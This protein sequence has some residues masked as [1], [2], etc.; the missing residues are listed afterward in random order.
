EKTLDTHRAFD[1]GASTI[2]HLLA[3][4]WNVPLFCGT[5]SR[6]VCDLNRS[7]HSASLWSDWTR[8]LP[9][10]RHKAILT[11]WYQPYRTAVSEAIAH[12]LQELNAGQRV[13]HLSL[14]SFTPIW[15][16]E[17][18]TTDLGLLYDPSRQPEKTLA[19]ALQTALHEQLPTA[20]IRR[21]APYRGT[22]DG[23]TT[24][25]RKHYPASH[26]LGFELECNQGGRFPAERCANVVAHALGCALEKCPW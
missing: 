11:R 16:G 20:R 10:A 26:Y 4:R 18:R 14:H 21:N 3:Q 22:A 25:L 8:D 1:A 2:A 15:K 13:L 7:E 19:L 23:L 17:E 6:L 9:A 24:T 12:A 5:V